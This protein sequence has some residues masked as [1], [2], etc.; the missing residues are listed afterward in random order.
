MTRDGLVEL[1]NKN[2]LE[3][4]ADNALRGITSGLPDKLM[5]RE[6]PLGKT[7]KLEWVEI[8]KEETNV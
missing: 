8:V 2:L 5:S 7:D 3:E 6:D 1:I 4:M